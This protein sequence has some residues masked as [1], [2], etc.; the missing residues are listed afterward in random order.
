[1]TWPPME[2]DMD[3]NY[4]TCSVSMPKLE[5][6]PV[7]EEGGEFSPPSNVPITDY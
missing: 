3:T 6:V 7:T 4:E 2:Q 5:G 1:M